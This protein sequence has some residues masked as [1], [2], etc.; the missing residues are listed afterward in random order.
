MDASNLNHALKW[1]EPVMVVAI[2]GTFMT[3]L[4]FVLGRYV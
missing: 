1:E 3:I 4:L 2:L